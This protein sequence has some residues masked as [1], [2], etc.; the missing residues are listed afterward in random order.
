MVRTV[1][2]Q[3]LKKETEGLLFQPFPGELGEKIYDSISQIAW[4]EWLSHQT[5]FINEYR[6]NLTDKK[7]RA[8]LYS[9]MERFL[10]DSKTSEPKIIAEV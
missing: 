2:C 4:E 8:F 9:E 3:K 6:L 10:F 7:A 5:R 1:Y